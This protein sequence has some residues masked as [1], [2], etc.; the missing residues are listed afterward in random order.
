MKK[1]FWLILAVVSL[2][3]MLILPTMANSAVIGAPVALPGVSLPRIALPNF[4]LS[5]VTIS[6][7]RVELSNPLLQPSLAPIS[8]PGPVPSTQKLMTAAVALPAVPALTARV[9]MTAAVPKAAIPTSRIQGLAVEPKAARKI[10]GRMAVSK[11]LRLAAPEKLAA[12]FDG[13][14]QTEPAPVPVQAAQAEPT[15]TTDEG[16][17][18]LTLPESDL[19]NEIG[20]G[21]Y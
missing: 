11:G 14:A 5:P 12:L 18:R 1:H 19:L 20:V 13:A 17:S 7:P 10:L 9:P 15:A 3:G 2:L 6:G 21:G 8:L 16:D 4:P